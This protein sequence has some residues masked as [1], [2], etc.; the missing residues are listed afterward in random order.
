MILDAFSRWRATNG[1][2]MFHCCSIFGFNETIEELKDLFV[3]R[4][5]DSLFFILYQSFSTSEGTSVTAPPHETVQEE[6][7]PT[8]GDQAI[9]F[10]DSI[11]KTL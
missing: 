2:C 7:I 5:P 4:Y 11:G 8:A 3:Y 6:A 9:G 10:L 1:L